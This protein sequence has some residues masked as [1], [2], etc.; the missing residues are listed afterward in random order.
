M[1]PNIV[2][3][4]VKL[5]ALALAITFIFSCSDDKDDGGNFGGSSSSVGSSS[6]G[7]GDDSSSSAMGSGGSSS[8]VT[9]GSYTEKG[10]DIANYRTV[11]IGGQ[12]WMAE[13]LNYN[14]SGSRC[15]GEGGLVYNAETWAYDKTLSSS[16]IQ[17]NC[18]RYGRLYDWATAINLFSSCNS[19]SCAGQ[20]SANHRGICPSGWHIPSDADW[21][22]L[23]KFINPSCSDNFPC[24]GVGTKLKSESGWDDYYEYDDGIKSDAI[25]GNG[26]DK[27]RFSALPGGDRQPMSGPYPGT[28]SGVGNSSNWWKT[29]EH[30]T[31]YAC[32]QGMNSSNHE[33]FMSCGPK[34]TLKSVRCVKD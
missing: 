13:N 22:V 10:N 34:G 32:Y 23:M 19:S 17:S 30:N 9:D 25:S 26:T 31:D 21:N 28:F 6:S 29:S 11:I 7:G 8:S 2:P 1:T 27:F 20:I 24:D 3:L 14:V 12:T 4:F 33:V 16:E 5:A 18:D 15:Y